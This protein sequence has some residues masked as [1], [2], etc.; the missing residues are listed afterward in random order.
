MTNER[1]LMSI[2]TVKEN[3]EILETETPEDAG[4]LLQL[5]HER[6]VLELLQAEAEG[7]LIVLPCKV[8]DTVYISEHRFAA[9]IEEIVIDAMS[10]I[11]FNWAEYDR[12]PEETELWDDGWFEPS[13][14][15]KTV[16]LSRAEAEAAIATEEAK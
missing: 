7:R 15:G 2:Q 9:Q 11:T 8:G 4:Y 10:G 13:D 5:E 16:F 6:H 14:F 3:I 12:G 1:L